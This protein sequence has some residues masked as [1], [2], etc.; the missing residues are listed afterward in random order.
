MQ[1]CVIFW[2]I[3]CN[4]KISTILCGAHTSMSIERE[5]YRKRERACERECGTVMPIFMLYYYIQNYEKSDK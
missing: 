3:L 4:L 2:G 1:M 5:I